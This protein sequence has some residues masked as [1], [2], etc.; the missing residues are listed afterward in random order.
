MN[1]KIFF[2][3][4]DLVLT[5]RVS[6]PKDYTMRGYFYG[7][8][9]DHN[10]LAFQLEYRQYFWR[11]LGF[12]AFAG[13]GDVEDEITRFSLTNLKH[14]FGFGLRFLF[15]QEEKINLRMDIGFGQD[16]NGIYFGMEEAF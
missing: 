1:T 9:R 11:R 4:N 7:R 10:Y 3:K 16:T 6:L 8:Y 2:L 5:A 14:T 15:N 12:V 13:F